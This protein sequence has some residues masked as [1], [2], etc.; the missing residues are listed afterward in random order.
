MF[1]R[2]ANP[3]YPDGVGQAYPQGRKGCSAHLACGCLLEKRMGLGNVL[4]TA[5]SRFLSEMSLDLLHDLTVPSM[6]SPLVQR[7]RAQ[8]ISSRVYLVAITF[9]ILTPLWIIVDVAF[10]PN[11]LCWY[12]AGLRVAA[13]A[14]FGAVALGFSRNTE[15]IDVALKALA[16]LLSVPVIFFLVSDPLMMGYEFNSLQLALAAG[17]AFLPFVMVAG[18]SV[19]PIT[20]IE[21]AAFSAPLIL[22]MVAIVIGGYELLPFSSYLGALWLLGL[23]AVV[24][25]LAGM[26]QLHFMMALV[27]Q[28]S[29]D[30]LTRVYTRRVGEELL[31]VQFLHAQRLNMPMALAFVDLDNFKSV[32]DV[33]GHEEGD[34]TLIRASDSLRRILR[35]G[36]IVVRWGGEEFLI[37]M[38][39]TDGEGAW[40]A[41][42][43]L[44][45]E[46][47]GNRPDGTPQTASIGIA[48]RCADKLENWSELVEKADQR[49]YRAKKSG[50]NRVVTV[51]E[52]MRTPDY[53]PAKPTVKEDATV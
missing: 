5:Q 41:I 49:M 2:C 26:S 35:R 17:Y 32:N 42:E 31:N 38:P 33:Y 11:P 45:D 50:K 27:N 13:A 47:L 40:T 34:R 3:G 25:T 9:A 36:D 52:E 21:G 51:G 28:A 53:T 37:I 46:G 16:S 14:A 1:I 7:R 19:F 4:I 18:L 8:L 43:R 29:H 44:R 22:S 12:L 6:H 20:A 39:N 23:L 48:E 15:R 30:V 10:F 24:A